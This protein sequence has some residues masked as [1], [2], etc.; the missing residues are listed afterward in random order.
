MFESVINVREKILRRGENTA[1]IS[2]V[3]EKKNYKGTKYVT[4][5]LDHFA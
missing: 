3:N 4:E 2:V 1:D 5:M